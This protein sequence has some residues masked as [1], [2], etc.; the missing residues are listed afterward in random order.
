MLIVLASLSAL[1][2]TSLSGVRE[3]SLIGAGI[4]CYLFSTLSTQP[5]FLRCVDWAAGIAPLHPRDTVL[6]MASLNVILIRR[7]EIIEDE[8]HDVD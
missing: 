8:W 3:V 4:R 1:P 2:R 5:K 7:N 6:G